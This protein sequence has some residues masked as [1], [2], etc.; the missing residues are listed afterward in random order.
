MLYVVSLSGI[1]L[2]VRGMFFEKAKIKYR[3][4]IADLI[5][6]RGLQKNRM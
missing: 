6:W 1:G 5:R 3:H 2:L 4:M